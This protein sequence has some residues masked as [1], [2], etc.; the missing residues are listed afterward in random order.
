MVQIRKKEILTTTT[1]RGFLR[2]MVILTPL[3]IGLSALRNWSDARLL[4]TL[5]QAEGPFYPT[6][7]PIDQDADLTFTSIHNK[8]AQAVLHIVQGGVLNI[9][10]LPVSDAL[11]E[12]WYANK[13]GPYQDRQDN[14]NLPWDHGFQGFGMA[15]TDKDGRYTIK[16]IRPAGYDYGGIERAPHIHFKVNGNG[17]NELVTQLYFAGEPENER[18]IFLSNIERKERVVVEFQPTSSGEK[19]G[20]FDL[21][22]V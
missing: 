7:K 15:R 6:E 4:P 2:G 5:G 20:T 18:D 10:R 3:L 1:T 12:I 22:L 8:R 9:E 17:F 19:P 14:F 21:V 16:T 13:W 11:I